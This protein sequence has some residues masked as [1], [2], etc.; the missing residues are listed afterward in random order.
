MMHKLL[1][2]NQNVAILY[3]IALCKELP[4]ETVRF[5]PLTAVAQARLDVHHYF[6]FRKVRP[7]L[8]SDV[9]MKSVGIFHRHLRVYKKV[10]L[11]E[12]RGA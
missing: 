8:R 9:V 3:M 4:V 2:K 12:S 6:G 11:D 5:T 10:K 7:D 1:A